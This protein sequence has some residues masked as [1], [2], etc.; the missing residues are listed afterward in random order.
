[1]R[2]VSPHASL[3]KRPTALGM[4]ADYQ[5]RDW[6]SSLLCIVQ[7]VR[8]RIILCSMK[9]RQSGASLWI[10]LHL[11]DGHFAFSSRVRICNARWRLEVEGGII[12]LLSPNEK[13]NEYK[14]V[15]F[16]ALHKARDFGPE[17][18]LFI[19]NYLSRERDQDSLVGWVDDEKRLTITTV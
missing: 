2:F 19:R 15:G 5:E 1:M 8:R 13:E 10:V 3:W 11:M 17:T 16:S 18:T 12:L 4:P 6:T 14:R 7:P 9:S